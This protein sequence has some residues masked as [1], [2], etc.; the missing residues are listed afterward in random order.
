[1]ANRAILSNIQDS[2]ALVLIIL[3]QKDRYLQDWTYSENENMI[4][5]KE[6]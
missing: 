6:R 2:S 5:I 3:L 1:M 4:Y